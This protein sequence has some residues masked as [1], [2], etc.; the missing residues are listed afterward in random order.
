MLTQAYALYVRA[1][2]PATQ[3]KGSANER[4]RTTIT[5]GLKKKLKELMGEFSGMR[6]RIQ[7]EYR[8]VVEK[9]VYTVTGVAVSSTSRSCNSMVSAF[10]TL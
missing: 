3:G 9:R 8:E 10:A 6:N 4:T 7:D 5:A 2:S 1:H